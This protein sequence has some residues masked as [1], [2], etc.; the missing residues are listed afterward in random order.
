M[1]C[2]ARCSDAFI[3]VFEDR[4]TEHPIEMTRAVEQSGRFLVIDLRDGLPRHDAG[5]LAARA[6]VLRPGL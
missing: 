5:D 4:V 1:T 2:T 3:K 6:G